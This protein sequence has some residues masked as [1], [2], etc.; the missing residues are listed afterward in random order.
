MSRIAVPDIDS[1][2]SAVADIY[3][4][5]RKISGGRVP[6]TYAALGYLVP[7][8]LAA[9]LDAQ[10]TLKSGNLNRQEHE[11]IK[12]LISAKTGL[13][14]RIASRIRCKPH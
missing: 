4:R 11:I 10:H 14:S 13:V 5:I 8:S 1:A 7:A 3:A 9:V 12:L 6:N 2:T